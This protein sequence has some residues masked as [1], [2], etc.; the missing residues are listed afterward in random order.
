MSGALHLAIDRHLDESIAA[1]Q[2]LLKDVSLIK[3]LAKLAQDCHNSLPAGGKIIFVGNGGSFA[4]AQYLAAGIVWRFKFDRAPL[5]SLA[6]ATN[7]SAISAIG[8]ARTQECHILVGHILRG[9]VE[10]I[11]FQNGCIQ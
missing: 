2:A 3:Q 9:H 4:D 8:N 5:A 10:S 11:Y 6:L 1:K 7:S